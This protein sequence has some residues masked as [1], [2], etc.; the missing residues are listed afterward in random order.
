MTQTAV[1]PLPLTPAP[2][3][4]IPLKVPIPALKTP[5]RSPSPPKCPR[6]T[7]LNKTC[8]HKTCVWYKAF[9]PQRRK[10][11]SRSVPMLWRA[12]GEAPF[13]VFSRIDYAGIDVGAQ[14][15]RDYVLNAFA[16][17]FLEECRTVFT[18]DET[19]RV[20]AKAMGPQPKEF[21][22]EQLYAV[23]KLVLQHVPELHVVG[24]LARVCK[25]WRQACGCRLMYVS[26]RRALARYGAFQS[27][28]LYGIGYPVFPSFVY[29]HLW[30][31]K[32]LPTSQ[33][34][35]SYFARLLRMDLHRITVAPPVP[36]KLLDI[37]V[38]CIR[39]KRP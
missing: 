33:G 9:G 28:V 37:N 14:D 2:T 32:Y 39:N 4:P 19:Q 12:V 31:P 5:R 29:Y 22:P 30:L 1:L 10:D 16:T 26:G 35:M 7:Y 6:C 13:Q 34:G 25:A 18:K 36:D 17:A 38:L 8:D 23:L 15:L 3:T 24:K 27:H 21:E 20:V 11:K